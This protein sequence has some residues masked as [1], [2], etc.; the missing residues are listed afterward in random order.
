[1]LP[2]RLIG[3]SPENP[4]D[5]MGHAAEES[6]AMP[7]PEMTVF[8][9]LRR[10][11]FVMVNPAECTEEIP[12]VASKLFRSASNAFASR[13]WSAGAWLPLLQPAHRRHSESDRSAAALHK[14]LL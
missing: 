8:S 11:S 5:L 3:S 1:M 6:E 14:N 10:V 13:I 9:T 7:A 4:S 2:L 12:A